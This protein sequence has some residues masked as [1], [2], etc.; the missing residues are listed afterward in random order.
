MVTIQQRGLGKGLSALIADAEP[1]RAVPVST[2]PKEG[3]QNLAITSLK[4]GIYQ[5]RRKFTEEQLHELAQ[6]I[7]RNGIMQPLVVRKATDGKFEIIA[8]ERRWRA[9]RMAGLNAVPAI[10]RD[11]PDTQALEL[12][13][14]EN[15]QRQD[16]TPLEEAEGY[17]R[18]LQE[19]SYTQEELAETVGKSRS[20]ITN[21]LRLLNLPDSVKEHLD[22]GRLSMGHARA[23]LA[24]KDPA[25]AAERCISENWNVRQ[26]EAYARAQT[27]GV[28]PS[29]DVLPERKK[30]TGGPRQAAPQ[31]QALYP[32]IPKSEDVLALESMLTE[33]LDTKVEIREAE[34]GGT[35][36]IAY[37]SL[38]EL[39][40]ILR[41]LGGSM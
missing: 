3:L 13:L 7:E 27:Q 29:A 12:A 41:K 1:E 11:I 26:A 39:D 30:R 32:Q 21:L 36:E 2:A 23:L 17:K 19:F 37:A 22:S 5:P 10:I 16:L 15:I 6:S 14:I 38:M 40:R 20:H 35:I 34:E 31:A 24:A 8:G 18:L 28:E 25:E 4:P 33:V 9:A